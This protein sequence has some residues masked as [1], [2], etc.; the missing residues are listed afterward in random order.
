MSDIIKR[1][2][3]LGLVFVIAFV[4][5]YVFRAWRDGQPIFGF[6]QEQDPQQYSQEE[7]VLATES[8]LDP[9][10]VPGLVRVNDEMT[11]LVDAVV[12]SVVSI[13]TKVVKKQHFIDRLRGR[14]YEQSREIP[15]LGSGVI[16]SPQGHF[17]TNH[18]VIAGHQEIR[19]TLSDRRNLPAI[20]IGSDPLMD[21]ALLRIKGQPGEIF[22]PLKF[23][24]SDQVKVGQL[25]IAVGNPYGLEETVTTGRISAR[26]RSFSDGQRDMFQTDAAIN[27]G[28]SGGPL[29]NHLGEIIG[30]NALIYSTDQQNPSF[31]GIG[32][33]IP[34]NDVVRTMRIIEE[35]G[36]PVYGFLGIQARD[37][38]Q[39]LRNVFDY[40]G[41]GV[42]IWDVS[43]GSPASE[44]GIKQ[45][46]IVTAYNGDGVENASQ[47]INLVQRSQ[48]EEE[49]TVSI[50][51]GSGIVNIKAKVKE[52]DP[53]G[54]AEKAAGT[55]RLAGD[56]AIVNAV[57]LKVQSTRFAYGGVL[58]MHVLDNSYAHQKG[59]RRGDLVLE[60]NGSRVQN[61]QDFMLKLVATAAVQETSLLVVRGRRSFR[62]ELPQVSRTQSD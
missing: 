43:P 23:A 7:V 50:W 12:P 1:I 46:D 44:A 8:A 47:L 38:N 62:V 34:A 19:V 54:A 10:Q 28:N 25:A 29:L 37:L 30:I 22:Q 9:S 17:V 56:T 39:H 59:I 41:N 26:D 32:F 15:S 13:D 48:I 4:S 53:L 24:D 55:G 35:K 14:V 60:I 2:F 20:L 6:G 36:R 21:I 40:R 51:R 52:A 16:I 5:V 18:H 33:S 11:K 27:P 57:G 31:S 49:V 42:F 3:V 61:E 45:N 58:V